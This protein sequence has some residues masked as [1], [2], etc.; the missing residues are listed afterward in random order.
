MILQPALARQRSWLH[1]KCRKTIPVVSVDLSLKALVNIPVKKGSASLFPSRGCSFADERCSSLELHKYFKLVF[2]S[3]S[4]SQTAHSSCRT[5]GHPSRLE[6]NKASVFKH[7]IRC[8]FPENDSYFISP[9][10]GLCY[11]WM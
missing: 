5:A 8:F 10:L 2:C 7:S 9:W 1:A 6:L 11:R 4:I 3:E